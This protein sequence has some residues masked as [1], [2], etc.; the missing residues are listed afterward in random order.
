MTK[1]AAQISPTAYIPA[2]H[3]PI[4]SEPFRAA[5]LDVDDAPKF[6]RFLMRLDRDSLYR[7]FGH[8]LGAEAVRRHAVKALTDSVWTFGVSDGG[9]L[10][11]VI[12]LYTCATDRTLDAALVVEKGWRRRGLAWALLQ[13]ARASACTGNTILLA[14][15]RDNWPMRALAV[16]AKARLSL[17]V[18]EMVAEI[19]S[20]DQRKP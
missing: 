3:T 8:A 15:A 7:R 5:R 11:G 19:D 13:H 20:T 1:T 2:W 16:K 4:V 17:V 12:E 9:D 18:G 6:Q 10:R 14:F